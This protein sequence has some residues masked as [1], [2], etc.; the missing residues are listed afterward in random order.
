MKTG[1]RLSSDGRLG[2]GLY[3][4]SKSHAVSVAKHREGKGIAV[5]FEVLV[6]ESKCL[7]SMHPPWAGIKTEFKEWCMNGSNYQVLRF[8]AI[9]EDCLEI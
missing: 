2:K 4:A 3:L 7:K 1:L 6:N 9:V 5:V 8:F